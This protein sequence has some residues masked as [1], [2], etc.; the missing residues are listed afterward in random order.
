MSETYR[1]RIIKLIG[2]IKDEKALKLIYEIAKRF[3]LS[4]NPGVEA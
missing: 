2:S 3:F 4:E 1:S